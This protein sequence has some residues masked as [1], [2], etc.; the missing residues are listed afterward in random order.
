[1]S[2]SQTITSDLLVKLE[3]A[4]GQ[5]YLSLKNKT[6]AIDQPK[7]ILHKVNKAKLTIRGGRDAEFGVKSTGTPPTISLSVP[8]AYSVNAYSAIIPTLSLYFGGEEKVS[9]ETE[10]VL[11]TGGTSY[12]LQPFANSG[13]FGVYIVAYDKSTVGGNSILVDSI[14]NAGATSGIEVLRGTST[15]PTYSEVFPENYISSTPTT[16]VIIGKYFVGPTGAVPNAPVLLDETNLVFYEGSNDDDVVED[17][18]SGFNEIEDNMIA[19]NRASEFTSIITAL[20]THVRNRS[21]QSFKDYYKTNDYEFTDGFRELFSNLSTDE[22]SV[23]LSY[24]YPSGSPTT[25]YYTYKETYKPAYLEAVLQQ[26]I[27]NTGP[28]LGLTMNVFAYNP[29]YSTPLKYLLDANTGGTLSVYTKDAILS[30]PTAGYMGIR[31]YSGPSMHTDMMVGTYDRSSSPTIVNFRRIVGSDAIYDPWASEAVY[32]E[33][34]VVNFAA[35]STL[36][37][38]KQVSSTSYRGVAYAT[39]PETP[40]YTLGVLI[41]SR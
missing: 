33:K 21:G 34:N 41:R 7:N 24:A 17:L 18:F 35:G 12:L 5:A 19:A 29:S 27:T 31:G 26:A 3:T 6:G 36:G 13:Y 15:V 23:K 14:P 2:A 40:G 25:T 37:A 38:I 8:T 22:L 11:W 9:P 32:V 28:T 39:I 10:V 1:M 30:W 4:L 16:K 20:S